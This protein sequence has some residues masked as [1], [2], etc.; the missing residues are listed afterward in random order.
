MFPVYTRKPRYVATTIEPAD[1]D[2]LEE[3]GQ[4]YFAREIDKFKEDNELFT[5][6]AVEITILS[7]DISKKYQLINLSFIA[8]GV[9]LALM[10]LII[11][12]VLIQQP[13][14]TQDSDLQG[15]N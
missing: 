15:M 1:E 4:K 10:S 12:L 8:A 3:Q 13:A 6:I 11:Y 5:A 9:A 14:L 7:S 2:N